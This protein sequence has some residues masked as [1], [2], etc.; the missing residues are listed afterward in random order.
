MPARFLRTRAGRRRA[1][2]GHHAAEF[3]PCRCGLV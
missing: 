2:R 3:S 1:L